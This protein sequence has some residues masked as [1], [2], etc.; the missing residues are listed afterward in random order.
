MRATTIGELAAAGY[1][2]FGDGYRTKRAELADSGYRIIRVADIADG[3]VILQGSDFV[4]PE[5]TRSIGSKAGQAGD[6][7]LTT[8]GTV[9][10]VAV[11]HG[12]MEDVVYSP[13]LCYFRVRSNDVLIADYLQYWFQSEDFV[14]QASY[15]KSNTDMAD[16]I[17]LADVRSLKL[18]L[19][20]LD[21]QYRVARVLT[22][23]DDKIAANR[24]LAETADQ[25]VQN[26]FRALAAH[27]GLDGE[28]E[29]SYGEIADIGGGGTPKTGIPEYWDGEILWA[30]PTDITGLDIPAIG[31]TSRSITQEGLANSSAKLYPAGSILMTSRATIGAF[32]VAEVP[33]AVNQGFIVVNAKDPRD[34]WW[35]FHD[36]RSRVDEFI[37]QANGATFLELPRGRFK[38]LPVHIPSRDIV[39]EFSAKAAELHRL[40][41]SAVR[42]SRTLRLIRDT[43]LPRLMSGELRVRDAEKSLEQVL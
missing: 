42:E 43:L 10:R 39:D 32:A 6:I 15:R 31:S 29:V 4:G 13:Q 25:L 11:F 17:N 22:A 20:S 23:L 16:Y 28:N 27:S 18:M 26:H 12:A 38:M 24:R 19:P 3:R 35:L 41:V 14:S 34:Q 7:L 30:T 40:A 5:R 21:N 33:V 2:E 37:A 9:G 36:M 1:L 8:K